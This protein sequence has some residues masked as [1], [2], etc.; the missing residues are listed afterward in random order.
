VHFK[1]TRD[2]R[3][4]SSTRVKPAGGDVRILITFEGTGYPFEQHYRYAHHREG[5]A[6]H[7][8]VNMEFSDKEPGLLVGPWPGWR[9]IPSFPPVALRYRDHSVPVTLMP[10]GD[11]LALR[12]IRGEASLDL[13]QGGTILCEVGDARLRPVHAELYQGR[14]PAAT[15]RP[16]TVHPDIASS[17]PRLLFLPRDIEPLRVKARGSHSVYWKRVLDLLE[18]DHLPR[19]LTPESKIPDG[20]E[21]LGSEDRCLIAALAAVIEPTPGRQSGAKDAFLAYMQETQQP[22]YQSLMIDTQ[23]GETLFVLS[24]CYDWT[25]GEWTESERER[26]GAWIREVAGICWSFLGYERSDYG[27]AHYLGCA[28]GLIAYSFLFWDEDPRAREWG[29]LFRGVLDTVIAMIP[30]DGFHPHG[31]NLW[32]YEYGFLLRWL[33]LFR[34]CTGTDLW[35][36]PLRWENASVF[37][38][39]CT[40]PD[41]L[42]GITFGDPQFRVGGDSWCHYLIAARTRSARAQWLGDR[43]RELTPTGVDFRSAPPRRRVY[44]FLFHDDSLQGAPTGEGIQIFRDGGQL[45]ARGNG[46]FLFTFRAGSPLGRQRYDA[47][48]YG[49]YGH[50]DPSNGSFL[51]SLGTGLTV[52]GPGPT[53]RRDTSLHNTITVDGRGQ[54][55]DSTVWIPDFIPPEFVCPDPEFVAAGKCVA[56]RSA[57]AQS[58]LPHLNVRECLRSL[59][60]DTGRFIIGLDTV[61]CGGSHTIEW[62]LHATSITISGRPSGGTG[63]VTTADLGSEHDFCRLVILDPP[64]AAVETGVTDMVPAY[65]HDGARTSYLKLSVKGKKARFVWCI[66]FDRSIGAPGLTGK[67]DRIGLRFTG[68]PA[69]TCRNGLFT[70]EDHE[71]RS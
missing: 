66:M 7:T 18:G 6:P 11:E 3:V 23:A 42:Y 9:G 57:M 29:S 50:A 32:I 26:I 65:P 28:M 54:I 21:R 17:H 49:G 71:D 27:Q 51:V 41:G 36:P 67:G 68:G 10:W 14:T 2:V 62:N 70:A 38:G 53:Y 20:P 39:A 45:F 46:P 64:H 5:G 69:I 44:E 15:P 35:Q 60:V 4:F 34:V 12:A 13:S 55:G 22:G 43:L 48:V 63:P 61:N 8:F 25:H 47:G 56:I 33:E 37:R 52:S 59:W 30:E 19:E 40:S 58:Y 16:V 24:V 1:K 31:V